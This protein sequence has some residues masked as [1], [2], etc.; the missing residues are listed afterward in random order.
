MFPSGTSVPGWIGWEGGGETP[1]KE[2]E[3]AKNWW[4]KIRVR[5]AVMA[6]PEVGQW[7]VVTGGKIVRAGGLKKS[8]NV[9]RAADAAYW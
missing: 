9:Q 6:I 5:I 8:C 7:G 1:E 2:E 4:E 3:P